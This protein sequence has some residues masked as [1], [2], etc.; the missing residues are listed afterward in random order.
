MKAYDEI[1]AELASVCEQF[2]KYPEHV[3]AKVVEILGNYLTREG[4]KPA[5]IEDEKPKKRTR[6]DRNPPK[7][8]EELQRALSG[9][10]SEGR[11]SFREFC[12][13]SRVCCHRELE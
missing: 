12:E 10:P 3:Q 11:E 7:E 2:S 5:D 6:F 1:K 8:R 9:S 4:S 13:A